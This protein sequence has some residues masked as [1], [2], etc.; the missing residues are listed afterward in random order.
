MLW[1]S[2]S[3]G[4]RHVELLTPSVEVGHLLSLFL[5][6]V[7]LFVDLLGPLL[8]FGHRLAVVASELRVVVSH[9]DLAVMVVYQRALDPR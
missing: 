1:C 8:D 4:I 3:N 6:A 9:A 7:H 5:D 2:K